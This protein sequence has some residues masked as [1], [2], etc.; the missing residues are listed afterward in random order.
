M[1]SNARS[2]HHPRFHYRLGAALQDAGYAV[3]ILSQPLAEPGNVDVV[4]VEYLPVRRSRLTRIAA[5]PISMVRALRGGADAVHV[6]T[7]DMLPW[8]ALARVFTGRLILYESNDEHDSMMLIKE[9]IPSPLRPVLYRLV[10][11]LE[12]WLARRL[13]AAT[14]ALPATQ[15]KFER[16]GVR[17]VL[18]RNFP[19]AMV[20]QSGERGPEFDYDVLVGGSLPEDQVPLLADIARRLA[21]RGTPVR[22]LV[23]ARNYGDEDRRLLERAL[24]DA[25]VREGF[26]LRFNRPFTEM[27]ELMAACRIGLVLYPGGPNYESRIPLRIFEYMAAGMPF[28]ASDLPTTAEFTAGRGVADLAPAGDPAA[29]ADALAGLLADPARQQEMSRRGPELV[30]SEYN[31]GLESR[32]LIELYRELLGDSRA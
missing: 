16:A 2:A 7:F 20:V 6:L 26:D 13:D 28:V 5:A 10:R 25:G 31:W 15:A 22:W 19:P 8:A 23:A 30:S 3:T 24:T 4:P 18:V 11:W 1:V 17:S 9:W 21:E 12:P 29:L 14:T 32:R 27:S